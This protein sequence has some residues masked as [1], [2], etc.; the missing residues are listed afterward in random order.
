[1]AFKT[2]VIKGANVGVIYK[3]SIAAAAITPGYLLERTTAGTI[4]KHGTAGAAAQKLFARENEVVGGNIDTDYAA[5]DTVLMAH[6]QAGVEVFAI[7]A[8]SAAAIVIGDELE[9]DGLGG[10]RVVTPL[11][12][13]VG[14]AQAD[15]IMDDGTG[16]YSQT[17]FN[18][19][20]ATVAAQAGERGVVAIA[21]EAVDN[22]GGGT[23]VRIQ[24]EVV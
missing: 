17:I 23:E 11:T 21:L 6:C 2:I 9:S 10:L 16:T 5:L 8:A 24:V 20:F 1:M 13:A 3:E 19:N 12:Q 15:G 4:Q 7:L 22:S 18:N 14:S